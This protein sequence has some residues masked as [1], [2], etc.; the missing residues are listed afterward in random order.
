MSRKER[1]RGERE[2][3]PSLNEGR[4]KCATGGKHEEDKSS[5]L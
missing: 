4:S 3:Y 1:K 5:Y 2:V